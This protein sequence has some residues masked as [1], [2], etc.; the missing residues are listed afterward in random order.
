MLAG[1]EVRV[2]MLDERRGMRPAAPASIQDRRP[3][4]QA[5]AA[6]AA[7]WLPASP[8]IASAASIPLDRMA[9]P[10][11]HEMLAD[12][13]L[14]PTA[15]PQKILN[16]R[17]SIAG[18]DSSPTRGP[19]RAGDLSREGLYQRIIILLSLELW[20]REHKMSW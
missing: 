6:L 3:R 20:L 16:A 18:C 5:G 14:A 8:R 13:L 11:F 15:H 17:W 2:P 10:A 4:R 19:S 1:I 9:T 7:R 12:L